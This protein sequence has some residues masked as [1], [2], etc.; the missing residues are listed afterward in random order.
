[1]TARFIRDRR[2]RLF[3]MGNFNFEVRNKQDDVIKDSSDDFF[4]YMSG[5]NFI[6]GRIIEGRYLGNLD[7][8]SP[9]ID[10]KCS[11]V[12]VNNGKYMIN[13][14]QVRTARMVAVN[15][16]KNVIVIISK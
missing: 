16:K 13:G 15:N 5:V 7:D 12:A 11:Y 2:V 10:G 1:M 8:K 9:L 3:D 14:T 4:I 6:D